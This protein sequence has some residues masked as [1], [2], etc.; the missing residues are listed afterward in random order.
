MAGGSREIRRKVK[1]IKATKQITR[2][3]ELVSASKMKRAVH[4]ALAMRS[5]ASTA[6]VILTHLAHKT[7]SALHPLLAV[8]APHR[9]LAI[10][11]SSDRGLC[12][13]FNSLLFRRVLEHER[14]VK[15]LTP[16]A[17]IDYIAVGKRAQE[18]LARSG[19]TVVAA[20]S[21]MTSRPSLELSA[22]LAKIILD[23]YRA[24][25]AGAAGDVNGGYDRVVLLYQHF[26]SAL[27]QKPTAFQ[28]LPFSREVLEEM[29]AELN[30]FKHLTHGVMND[31]TEYLF[32]PSPDAI[33]ERLLPQLTDMQVFQ[34]LLETTASEHSA[35]MLAMRNATDSAGEIIDD[36]TLHLNQ[37]RQAGITR[38]IAEIS[39][40][41]VALGL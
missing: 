18:F 19:K 33:L 34:A 16:H 20:F 24:G 35:R 2:A 28:L 31:G 12:G 15:R 40:G 8:R 14:E 6:L 4:H 3:M 22:P 17:T 26:I 10:V 25:G 13:G 11:Y 5:Y 21:Q 23:A 37:I 7:D 32:E 41:K 27:T 36:L 38:E 29:G 39:A 9:Y 1:S 30:L